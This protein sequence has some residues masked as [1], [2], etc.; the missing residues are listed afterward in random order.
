MCFP[1]LLGLFFYKSFS[2]FCISNY[3][4]KQHLYKRLYQYKKN[5]TFFNSLLRNIYPEKL[6]IEICK[7][8]D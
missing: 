1:T 6:S 7:V 3:T 8:F 4:F 5:E 2:Q